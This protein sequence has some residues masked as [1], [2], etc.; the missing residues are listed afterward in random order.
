VSDPVDPIAA[1]RVRFLE[2]CRNDLQQMRLLLADPKTVDGPEVREL[3]HRLSGA[4]GTF[5]YPAISGLAGAIDDDFHDGRTVSLQDLN[6]L[7]EALQA[8]LPR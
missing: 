1:L 3:V 5:G 8:I 6:A 7:V 4:A 2:R